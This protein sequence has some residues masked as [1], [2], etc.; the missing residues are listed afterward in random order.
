MN[1]YHHEIA[2]ELR[3]AAIRIRPINSWW[4]GLNHWRFKPLE[5]KS[6]EMENISYHDKWGIKANYS[7]NFFNQNNSWFSEKSCEKLNNYNL[8]LHTKVSSQGL[9]S[10]SSALSCWWCGVHNGVSNQHLCWILT[11]GN[12]R[13]AAYKLNTH[14][15][16][17]ILSNLVSFV[18]RHKITFSMPKVLPHKMKQF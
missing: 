15:K 13:A 2:N 5:K 4:E 16:L 14:Q 9:P 8:L 18:I 7:N 11:C 3:V 10:P 1:V 17:S 6:R 12:R